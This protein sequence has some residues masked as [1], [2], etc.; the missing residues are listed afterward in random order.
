MLRLEYC[1]Y[2]GRLKSE[3][4][5]SQVSVWVSQTITSQPLHHGF[6]RSQASWDQ[7]W[8]ESSPGTYISCLT[9]LYTYVPSRQ[10]SSCTW[11]LLMMEASL[12]Q[13][14]H[15]LF[16]EGT[17]LDPLSFIQQ[18]LFKHL[19]CARHYM[20]IQG[21]SDWVKASSLP[22]LM[23]LMNW[24]ERKPRRNDCRKKMS[25]RR[26][27]R[28]AGCE[29]GLGCPWGLL[30]GKSGCVSGG[31]RTLSWRC[32]DPA[33]YWVQACSAHCTTGQIILEVLRQGVWLYLESQLTK[34][35]E[36]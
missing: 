18:I 31:Q 8:S 25:K 17:S 35:M 29:K 5:L 6:L 28:S 13:M 26:W 22:A 27:N 23:K 3:L 34:K 19:L 12:S 10:T 7:R 14:K 21:C 24:W 1:N 20:K 11:M 33:C 36:D 15:L 32:D 9:P 30:V 4:D 16:L 2:K